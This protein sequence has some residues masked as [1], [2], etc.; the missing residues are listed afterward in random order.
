[1]AWGLPTDGGCR[2]AHPSPTARRRSAI[3]WRRVAS[4]PASCAERIRI[5][6]FRV[7]TRKVVREGCKSRKA[8][9]V[10][11]GS[12][13]SR[14]VGGRRVICGPAGRRTTAGRRTLQIEGREAQN[15]TNHET[16]SQSMHSALCIGFC[17]IWAA[18]RA[19]ALV[20]CGK[21]RTRKTIV[22]SARQTDKNR[23]VL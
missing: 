16:K 23:L 11:F 5:F 20:F 15:H 7:R 2:G 14:G 1:V 10:A 12:P 19:Y 6:S 4:W 13:I 3:N 18:K 22:L 17:F 8:R 9:T 21:R